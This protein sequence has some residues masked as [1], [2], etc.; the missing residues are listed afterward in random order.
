VSEICDR[1]DRLPL[2]VELAAARVAILELPELL[3]RLDQRLPLLTSRARDVPAR[4]QTLRAT[5]E[6]SYEL[7][8]SEEQQFFRR[9]SVFRGSFAVAAAEVV[10]TAELETVESLVVKNLVRR[11]W[12]AAVCCSSTPSTSTPGSSSRRR[13]RPRRFTAGT[14]SSSWMWQIRPT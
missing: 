8:D 1:L 10:F 9:V 4:Q 12:E 14:R 7:L 13:L 3:R 11:R 6:W 2:A 5:I